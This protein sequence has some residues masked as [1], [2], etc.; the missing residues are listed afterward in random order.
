MT[1]R[2]TSLLLAL[3]LSSPAQAELVRIDESAASNGGVSIHA[4]LKIGAHTYDVSGTLMRPTTGV[5]RRLLLETQLSETLGELAVKRGMTAAAI[6]LDRIPAQDRRAALV[7][8]VTHFRKTGATQILAHAHGEGAD[9]LLAQAGLFD[10]LLLSDPRAAPPLGKSPLM[11]EI[12]GAD[13]FW[14][15][16]SP[17]VDIAEPKGLRRFYVAGALFENAKTDCV[18]KIN[19]RP[20][21][22][23]LRALFV[24]LDEWLDGKSP[25]ASRMPKSADFAPAQSL[26]WPSL[27]TLFVPPGG[28]RRLTKIDADGNE[29]SGLRLPDQALPLATFI[30][31]NESKATPGALCGAGAE[32][33]F[34][35]TKADRDKTSDPRLSL[36]ERYG[37]RAYFV[38]TMRVVADSLAKERLLLKEDAD[39]YVAAAKQAPF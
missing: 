32:F 18:A 33:P 28:D 39:A 30:A 8:F 10:A 22:P 31:F 24:A 12:F 19:V 26:R 38:A 7:D 16:R 9:W 3:A 34:A 20:I 2:L 21:G 6:S 15:D 25:P 5:P 17:L 29:T 14:R 1:P 4:N 11:I 36:V 27:P 35:A 23:A 13:A 37:S